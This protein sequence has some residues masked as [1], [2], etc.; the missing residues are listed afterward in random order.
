MTPLRESVRLPA[1]AE[2]LDVEDR[3]RSLGFGLDDDLNAFADLER[4]LTRF[5][6]DGCEVFLLAKHWGTPE[7][8]L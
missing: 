3:A 4:L 8:I 1:D 7:D 5:E 2:P 6:H